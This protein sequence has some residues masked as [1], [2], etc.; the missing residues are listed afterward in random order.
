MN[1]LPPEIKLRLLYTTAATDARTL[2]SL[3][4][5]DRTFRT[6]Y[7]S[8]T[9]QRTLLTTLISN[10]IPTRLLELCRATQLLPSVRWITFEE[11][12]STKACVCCDGRKAEREERKEVVK[13]MVEVSDRK[14][15]ANYRLP[16]FV[17]SST[18]DLQTRTLEG[19]LKTQAMINTLYR[20]QK[21][22]EE[23]C[24]RECEFVY[25]GRML[26]VPLPHDEETILG[27]Y[28]IYYAILLGGAF[29]DH[30]F[31][32]EDDGF[33]PILERVFPEVYEEYD[34]NNGLRYNETVFRMQ[35]LIEDLL[36]CHGDP[37][38]RHDFPD[39]VREMSVKMGLV[40]EEEAENGDTRYAD[41]FRGTGF[42]YLGN[43]CLEEVF[44]LATGTKEER[45]KRYCEF[46][47]GPG[48]KDHWVLVW[49][50][51]VE[52]RI[53]RDREMIKQLEMMVLEDGRRVEEGLLGGVAIEL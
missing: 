29:M 16:S 23:G 33:A 20:A 28:K 9:T 7:T 53:R 5:V 31:S 41:V 15:M 4:S 49:S 13:L 38:L 19:M 35:D 46:A 52:S 1:T 37:L 14:Y 40:T 12:S 30:T 42:C 39:R 18:R 36:E 24:K 10:L 22:F 2:L 47:F 3:S 6:L 25:D 27:V 45:L 51:E 11:A 50:E 43:S 32:P 34:E 17:D 8:S 26:F 48:E 21:A 44:L